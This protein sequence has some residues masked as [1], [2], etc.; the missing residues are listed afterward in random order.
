MA[1]VDYRFVLP[2]T[3]MTC[4]LIFLPTLTY[5]PYTKI[6]CRA[7]ENMG[8]VKKPATRGSRPTPPAK[9][10][11]K[12]KLPEPT[13][14]KKGMLNKKE[15]SNKILVD[16]G[17][18]TWQSS[19]GAAPREIGGRGL[20]SDAPIKITKERQARTKK[21]T[22]PSTKAQVRD[23]DN[24][25]SAQ[26][27]ALDKA[28]QRVVHSMMRRLEIDRA[29]VAEVLADEI[30]REVN[31]GYEYLM[32]VLYTSAG[33]VLPAGDNPD[34]PVS[35]PGVLDLARKSPGSSQKGRNVPPARERPKSASPS[36]PNGVRKTRANRNL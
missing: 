25:I 28:A 16:A 11:V 14:T 9:P 8:R 24:D 29:L 6:S 36:P 32:G 15:P 12:S 2:A 18:Y 27:N 20:Q 19:Q 7:I 35:P 26:P 31:A 22:S 21:T 3:P 5:S 10:N 1:I 33:G 30:M 23:V 17:A 34:S 4:Q 13:W